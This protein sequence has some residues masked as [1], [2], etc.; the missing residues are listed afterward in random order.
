MLKYTLA[1]SIADII[2]MHTV[3]VPGEVLHPRLMLLSPLSQFLLIQVDKYTIDRP[4]HYL[5]NTKR[6]VQL[7]GSFKRSGVSP[8]R[9]AWA[10]SMFLYKSSNVDCPEK[11]CLETC[12][13]SQQ[14]ILYTRTHLLNTNTIMMM[15]AVRIKTPTTVPVPT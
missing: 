3:N 4:I 9:Q 10:C 14:S 5:E 15:I 11:T 13:P 1:A 2:Y 12:D 7:F 8:A 6:S